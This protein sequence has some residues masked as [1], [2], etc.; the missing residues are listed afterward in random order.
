MTQDRLFAGLERAHGPRPWGRVLDA[1]TGAHSLRWLLGREPD[2]VLGVTASEGMASQLRQELG[3]ALRPVDRLLVGNWTDPTLLH[4]ERFDVVLAD[5]LLGAVDG[6][7]PYFQDQL[8][9]R[10]RPLVAGRLYAVGLEPLP[11]AAE[12]EGGRLILELQRLRDACILLAGH[13]CYR[14][15][16]LSWV[17]RHIERAGLVVEDAWSL[18]V[19]YRE[20]YLQGQL[21][22]CERKLPLLRDRG[23]AEALAHTI[24]DLRARGVAWLAAHPEGIPL[25]SDWVVVARA[26][27]QV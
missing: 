4:G 2:Q 1:G 20:R 27:D 3:A 14:E 5:Y 8:F 18:P 10:L 24:A 9:E 19:V 25:G 15:F 16:P 17:L 12:S 21:G 11:D 26:P 7:A 13:R 23:L 22:V 6:F